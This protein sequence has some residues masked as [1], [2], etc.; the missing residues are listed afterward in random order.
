MSNGNYT[1][2]KSELLHLSL[3]ILDAYYNDELILVVIHGKQGYGK[4][5]YAS[6]VLAQVY[7]YIYN[8]EKET[9]SFKYDWNKVKKHFVF[10]PRDFLTLSR[11][12]TKKAPATVI[13]DA[14]L[15]LNNMDYHNPMVKAVGKFMEVGRTKWGAILFTCSDMAQVITKIR[16]MPHVY[17]V[18]IIK[19]GT[20]KTNPNRRMATIY[21]GWKSEDMK[22]A[23]RTT[24]YVDIFHA[25][26]P[27]VFYDWYKPKRDKLAD[28]G[29]D[30]LEEMMDRIEKDEKMGKIKRIVHED[31]LK[32]RIQKLK[33]EAMQINE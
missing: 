25:H 28:K 12:Q 32:K 15:W 5:T 10:Q 3:L 31:Q 24:K 30:E 2:T 17:T 22:K 9:Q 23:G 6:I 4:S 8:Y 29:L 1:G 18:R 21:E 26:M 7:G 27:T 14:G 13:D 11:N 19:Q 16:N 33:E 20:S